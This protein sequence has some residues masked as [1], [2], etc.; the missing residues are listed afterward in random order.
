M[1]YNINKTIFLT[2]SLSPLNPGMLLLPRVAMDEAD[3]VKGVRMDGSASRSIV[4]P[5][6]S[7]VNLERSAALRRV[8]IAL[9]KR[10]ID[11]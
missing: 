3:N 6:V 5:N 4:C 8:L 7:N 2:D 11:Y 10:K 1:I 9:R